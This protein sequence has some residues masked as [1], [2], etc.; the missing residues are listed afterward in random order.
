MVIYYW[1]DVRK[2]ALRLAVDIVR[3]NGVES[4]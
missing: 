2:D 1:V 4:A 3:V